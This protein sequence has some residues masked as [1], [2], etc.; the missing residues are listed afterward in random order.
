MRPSRPMAFPK[1]LRA[2]ATL[3]RRLAPRKDVFA[4]IHVTMPAGA[5]IMAALTKTNTVRSRNDRIMV[6][7]IWGRLYGGSSMANA[8]GMPFR[9]VLDRTHDMTRVINIPRDTQTSSQTVVVL[10]L[11][12]DMMTGLK[13]MADIRIIAGN[14]PLQGTNVFVRIAISLSL[15]ESMILHATTPAA[16]HPN[17]IHIVK[18]CLPWLPTRLKTESM[19]NAILGR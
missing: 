18:A 13:K 10:I 14:L 11:A 16:L 2:F 15:G 7:S 1:G 3:R 17:P 19:L 4:R 6:L 12:A 5:E 9:T 8:E